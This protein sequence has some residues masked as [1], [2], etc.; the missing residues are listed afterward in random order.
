MSGTP[1][2]DYF[3]YEKRFIYVDAY[4][5]PAKGTHHKWRRIKIEDLPGFVKSCHNYN[6]FATIQQFSIYKKTDNEEQYAPFYFDF[7]AKGIYTFKDVQIDV[8][9]LKNYLFAVHEI[10]KSEVRFYF[11]GNRG[12]HVIINPITIG[13]EPSI[14]LTYI[15]KNIAFYLKDLLELNTLDPAVYTIRRV[16]R[17]SNSVH[18]TSGCYKIEL[19]PSEI[20]LPEEEIRKLAHAPRESL[21]DN[22]EYTGLI[23]NESLKKIYKYFSDIYKKQSE[24]NKLKPQ[25]PINKSETYPLC[26]KDLLDN[27]IRKS[28]IRNNATI[29]LAC[30]FKDQGIDENKTFEII[31]TWAQKVPKN[32]TSAKGNELKASTKSCVAS[33]YDDKSIEKN[34]HFICSAMRT[35]D[36][37]CDFDKCQIANTKDQEPEKI[38]E[39]ELADA[40]DGCFVGKRISCKVMIVGKNI[41]PF[42]SPQRIQLNCKD[43][44]GPEIKENNKCSNCLVGIK[45][46]MIIL[47][48]PKS[49]DFILETINCPKQQRDALL[50]RIYARGCN[51]VDL[52]ILEYRN[53][54]EVELNPSVEKNFNDTGEYVA[55]KGYFLGHKI[56][57]NQEFNIIGCIIPDPKTQHVIHFFEEAN[58]LE[59]SLSSFKMNADLKK[60]LSIFQ[61]SEK[62]TIAE[63]FNEIYN[64]L[65]RNVLHIWQRRAM[66]TAMDLV[67]HSALRFKLN[68]QLLQRGWTEA[69]I[70]GDSGQGK[71]DLFLKLR[72]H[73]NLGV[74]V[75]GEGSRRT[76]L[77]W[78]WQQST[79]QWFVRFGQI[80]NND[81][82]LVCIDEAAGMQEE[83][84]E[85]LTDMRESGIADATG[86]PIPAKAYARTRLIWMSNARNGQ[87]L[88]T[89]MFPIES[90]QTVFRKAEDIRRLDILIG[91]VTGSVSDN[92]IHQS[93][94]KMPAVEHKFTSDLSH[95]LVLWAWTRKPEDIVITD[96]ASNR[97]REVALAFG[98][99]Y[100]AKI[101]IVEPAVQRIKTA[102]LAV[103][104]AIR[105]FS[106][107]DGEKALVKPEHVNFVEEFLTSQYDDSASLDYLNYTTNNRLDINS[108]YEEVSKVYI[109][110]PESIELTKI[111]MT[112][113]YWVKNDLGDMIGYDKEQLQLVM[114]TLSKHRLIE[115]NHGQYR[116][117]TSG[118]DFVKRFYKEFNLGKIVVTNNQKEEPK[119]QS[120]DESKDERKEENKPDLFNKSEP[121]EPKI[122]DDL[123]QDSE[124]EKAQEDAEIFGL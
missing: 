13:I 60:K 75:S 97:I 107:E 86:G 59:T 102:R 71:S 42:L 87:S 76:G 104:V 62:Q 84:L 29:S 105:V 112:T 89:F 80:P 46:G 123:S 77:G 18:K 94:E 5:E 49:I 43:K 34:Y 99:K 45:G 33:I 12:M 110:L 81:R 53:I 82:R 114:K 67:Y 68:G 26:V 20:M 1:P 32:L 44:G 116:M 122:K 58:P 40:S 31:Y 52:D 121:L 124:Q 54:E 103:A 27:S 24:I 39:L 69:F 100:S 6:V 78:T 113:K 98:R 57:A 14:E 21:Y 55:R 117:T 7:D 111:L 65:E 74:R 15:F 92:V 66:I 61:L 37:Q 108:V 41:Y 83:E 73:Y 101:P 4:H 56:D 120:K 90:I 11:S 119:K 17:L 16:L 48:I 88:R 30:Y 19:N 115:K 70:I 36:V 38:I 106:T 50:K 91:V 25:K 28:G 10:D 63:K 47:D 22:S 85:K 72:N 79:N 35:L 96:E 3:N 51:K 23:P 93:A 9:K 109:T 8:E 95:H 64:D 2:Q 118:I